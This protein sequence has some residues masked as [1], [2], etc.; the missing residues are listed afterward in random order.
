[1]KINGSNRMN[2]INPY[3]KLNQPAAEKTNK[4]SFGKDEVKISSEALELMNM[5]KTES[6][7]RNER[8]RQ[9]KEQVQ[10]GTY[11]V[12]SQKLAEKMYEQFKREF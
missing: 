3:Q 6:T 10:S 4:T 12:D 5:K 11:K 7:E 2:G 8:I 1:M 9:L